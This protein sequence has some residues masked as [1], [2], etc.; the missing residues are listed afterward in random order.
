MENGVEE[1]GRLGTLRDRMERMVLDRIDGSHVNGAGVART[2]N[3]SNLRFEGIDSEPL[4]IALD[5]RGFAISSGSAC[6]SGASEPSHVLTAIGLSKEQARSSVRISLGRGND[7]AQVNALV[8][9]L[10][11]SVAHLRRLAPVYV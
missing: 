3:T 11:E 5:L 10:A 2:C 6:S 7:D 4:L 8:D 1:C 9:A